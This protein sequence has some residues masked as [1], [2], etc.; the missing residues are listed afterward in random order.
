MTELVIATQK[1]YSSWS[2]RGWLVM[3]WSGL[4]FTEREID[5][6]QPG[7]GTQRIEAVRAVSPGGSVPALQIDGATIWDSLTIAEWAAEQVPALWP[8]DPVARAVARS[9]TAEMHS[10]AAPIRRDLSMN[11]QRRCTAYDLPEETLH[12]IE[13]VQEIWRDCRERFGEGGPWLFGRRSIADAFYLP[14]ATRFRTYGIALDPV[15]QA[16]SDTALADPD[17]LEWEAASEP[18][19]WDHRGFSVI[20]GLFPDQEGRR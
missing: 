2:L 20:D 19:S 5:L 6:A 17:F 10:G 15:S 18:D 16:W 1:N 3:R 7:Y 9:I 12:A 11:I 14:V 8:S 13:R 4:A